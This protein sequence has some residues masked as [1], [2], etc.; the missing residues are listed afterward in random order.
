MAEFRGETFVMTEPK[1]PPTFSAVL[2]GFASMTLVHLGA[3]ANP[4]TGKTEVDLALA[5]QWIDVLEVLRE[6]TRGNLTPEEDRLLASLLAD[7][8]LRFVEKSGE[9]S[10]G[11]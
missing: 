5:R 1:G 3:S 8:R 9:K 10:G 4:E 6:K 7:V 11:G 2:L